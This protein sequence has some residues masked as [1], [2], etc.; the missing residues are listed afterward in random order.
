[1]YHI[2]NIEK[3]KKIINKIVW[4]IPFR[5]VRDLLREILLNMYNVHLKDIKALD[6]KHIVAIRKYFCNDKNFINRYKRLIY[7]LDIESINVVNK[8]ISKISNFD[9]IDD[10]V[11]FSRNDFEIFR[12][13]VE[14]EMSEKTIK[15][16]DECY[17][18]DGKY[19]LNESSFHISNYYDNMGVTNIKN[20]DIIRNKSI[21]DAGAYIGDTAILLSE[22]TDDKVYAF[23]PFLETFNYFKK[24]IEL[25]DIDNVVP[26]NMALGDENKDIFISNIPVYAGNSINKDYDASYNKCKINMITLDKFVED[27]NLEIGLIKTDLEGF[28]QAFLRGALNTI[29]KAK[30]YFINKHLSYI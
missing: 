29:K 22:Y 20:I 4:F 8:I 1:M 23:E 9:N 30:T 13:T 5:D 26:I 10:P 28:E 27:N 7:G 21:I 19:I 15:V 16:N 24:N 25:N 18:Y 2:P 12:N 17:I 3:V 14:K 6:S 11:T